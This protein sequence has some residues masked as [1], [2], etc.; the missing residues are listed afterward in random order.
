[1]SP[2][3]LPNTRE[4]TAAIHAPPYTGPLSAVDAPEVLA[5]LAERPLHTV[6]MAGLIRANGLVSPHNRGTFHACRDEEG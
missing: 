5:F 6:N 2:S 1:M 3:A 4:R